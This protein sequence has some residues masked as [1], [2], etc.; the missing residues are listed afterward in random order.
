MFH[1]FRLATLALYT[2]PHFCTVAYLVWSIIL[3]Y[4][5]FPSE[6]TFAAD[7]ANYLI[8]HSFSLQ[9]YRYT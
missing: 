4:S 5:V 6:R 9:F 2:V 8:L 1:L 3:C 7:A